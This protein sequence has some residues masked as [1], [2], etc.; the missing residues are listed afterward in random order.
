MEAIAPRGVAAVRTWAC[1]VGGAG[2]GVEVSFG[3]CVLEAIAAAAAAAAAVAAAAAATSVG[4]FPRVLLANLA[5]AAAAAL[6]C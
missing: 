5:A 6:V 3:G 4:S 1:C 2:A